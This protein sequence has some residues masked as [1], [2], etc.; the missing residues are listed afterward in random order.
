MYSSDAC[1]GEAKE[2]VRDVHVRVGESNGN[3]IG[4][5]MNVAEM[6]ERVH[7][8]LREGCRHCSMSMPGERDC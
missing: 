8:L 1:N 2:C 3:I 7:V 4:N 6:R 5:K